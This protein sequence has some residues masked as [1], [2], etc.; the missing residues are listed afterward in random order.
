M[1]L[2]PKKLNLIRPLKYVCIL[3][4]DSFQHC[5]T[6]LFTFIYIGH[7]VLGKYCAQYRNIS[8]DAGNVKHKCLPV[9]QKLIKTPNTHNTVRYT[10]NARATYNL[11]TP[12]GYFGVLGLEVRLHLIFTFFLRG[13]E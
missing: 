2:S 5:C 9:A 11:R 8:A 1:Q 13:G 4:V 7:I 6:I 10:C 3:R 12:L